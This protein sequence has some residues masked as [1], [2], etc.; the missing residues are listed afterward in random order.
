MRIE[1]QSRSPMMRSRIH[2]LCLDGQR[3]L[4][5]AALVRSVGMQKSFEATRHSQLVEDVKKIVFHRVL[6]NTKPLSDFAIAYSLREAP[7]NLL[8]AGGKRVRRG[9][10]HQAR[11]RRARERFEDVAKLLTG[12]PDL[13][14]V[15]AANALAQSSHGVRSNEDA[16]GSRPKG[17]DDVFAGGRRLQK[18]D[19]ADGGRGF[20]QFAHDFE[21]AIA[22]AF[23]IGADDENFRL[24][25]RD[26]RTKAR[27]IRRAADYVN[28]AESSERGREQ[29]RTHLIAICNQN[30]DRS[31][32][33]SA[34]RRR[35]KPH[36]G[37]DV[38]G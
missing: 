30:A 5:R 37:S 8:L 14:L 6:A 18:R 35:E 15:N 13:A 28:G 34:M 27:R 2:A 12:G 9:C 3:N 17:L 29:F 1:V 19:E 23:K 36:A 10:V 31:F 21:T 32:G 22:D 24:A 20:A 16:L 26:S 7:K 11:Q 25:T 4:L 38:R 33:K